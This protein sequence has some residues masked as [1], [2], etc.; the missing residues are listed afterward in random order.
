MIG[1][2][3]NVGKSPITKLSQIRYFFTNSLPCALRGRLCV[4]GH[5]INCGVERVLAGGAIYF[6]EN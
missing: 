1:K 5:Q 6:S 2:K 3:S 4:H